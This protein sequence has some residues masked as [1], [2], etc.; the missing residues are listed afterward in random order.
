MLRNCLAYFSQKFT[1]TKL[2]Y[3]LGS[4][5]STCFYFSLF[6]FCLPDTYACAILRENQNKNNDGYDDYDEDYMSICEF[7]SQSCNND[8]IL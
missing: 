6:L 7:E 1:G 2:V 3:K 4:L 5:I 8:M